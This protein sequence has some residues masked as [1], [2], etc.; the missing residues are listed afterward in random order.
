MANLGAKGFNPKKGTMPVLQWMPPHMLAVDPA[1]QRSVDN[2]ASQRLITRI[3]RDWD[4]DLC[5]PLVV[6]RRPDGSQWIVDGQHRLAAAVLRG[7]IEQL[8]CF[9]CNYPDAATEAQRFV[10]FNR[11]RKALKPLDLWHAAVAAQDPDATRIVALLDAVGLSIHSS[12]KNLDMPLGA[13]TAIGA[14]K[15]IYKEQGEAQLAASL[16]VLAQ[17]FKGESLRYSGTLLTGIAAIVADECLGKKADDWQ[18]SHRFGLL[19]DHLSATAQDSW[20]S[21]SVLEAAQSGVSRR[22]GTEQHF[23]K[24]WQKGDPATDAALG[25]HHPALSAAPPPPPAQPKHSSFEEQLA[26]VERGEVGIA[27]KPSMKG[28]DPITHSGSSLA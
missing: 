20:Y 5:Q 15:R 26:R 28:A 3:A 25:Q 12:S 18:N 10:D 23:R 16:D 9:I 19:T 27:K 13:L 4:W 6:S 1:Y 8:P 24:S 14:V 2:E 21:A 7:D 17:A 22:M 11:N